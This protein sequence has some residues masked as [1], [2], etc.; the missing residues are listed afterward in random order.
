M[1]VNTEIF[2]R[3]ANKHKGAIAGSFGGAGVTALLLFA[4]PYFQEKGES[5]SRQWQRITALEQ[6]VVVLETRLEIYTELL[7]KEKQ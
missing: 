2:K 3:A 1:N 7:K 6:K 4:I 5:D